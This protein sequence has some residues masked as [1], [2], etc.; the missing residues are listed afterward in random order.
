[1]M[2]TE[3]YLALL[4]KGAHAW[5]HWRDLNPEVDP[6]LARTSLNG[7]N[8]SATNLAG[9]GF[10]R[11][12]LIMANLRKADCRRANFAGANLRGAD[13]SSAD[14]RGASL[15]W[16]NL[17]RTNLQRA[18]L[19]GANLTG[20]DLSR[21]D[22]SGADLSG[23][24]VTDVKFTGAIMPDGL[25]FG[26]REAE[27]E[28]VLEEKTA[29]EENLPTPARPPNPQRVRRRLPAR[30][31]LSELA[32]PSEDMAAIAHKNGNYPR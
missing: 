13:L 19:S 6:D 31:R 30:P 23:A 27:P 26:I 1:M 16:A 32:P 18:N 21:A 7:T 22:L 8:L 29:P 4:E 28:I 20:A 11:A 25:P 17:A 9:M 15:K 2:E 5:N 3:Q 14:L 10:V 24:I 12:N